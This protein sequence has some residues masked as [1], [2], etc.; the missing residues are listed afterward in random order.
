MGKLMNCIGQRSLLSRITGIKYPL[1]W[2]D[3]EEDE[4]LLPKLNYS[5]TPYGLVYEESGDLEMSSDEE[6]P[7]HIDEGAVTALSMDEIRSMKTSKSFLEN[8]WESIV[9]TKL[10]DQ[11][12]QEEYAE[13]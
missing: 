8:N 3:F 6:N 13:I 11:D 10:S 4:S 2:Y 1:N 7:D 12:D 9:S 5:C